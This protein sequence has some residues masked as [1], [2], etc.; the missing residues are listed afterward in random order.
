[1]PL[2]ICQYRSHVPHRRLPRACYDVEM[3]LVSQCTHTLSDYE[4]AF[5]F[6]ATTAANNS[7]SVHY[8][9]QIIT[10]YFHDYVL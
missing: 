7:S 1:M 6:P 5:D 10:L 4:I 3:L 9:L 8:D 2:T